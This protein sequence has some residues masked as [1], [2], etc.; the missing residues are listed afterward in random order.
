MSISWCSMKSKTVDYNRAFG[1]TGFF[2]S[3][4]GLLFHAFLNVVRMLLDCVKQV[5]LVLDELKVSNGICAIGVLQSSPKLRHLTS[6][7]R[8]S[9]SILRLSCSGRHRFRGRRR[10]CSC[11][12]CLTALAR[13]LSGRTQ[14]DSTMFCRGLCTSTTV[15]MT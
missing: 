7:S 8:G 14:Y 4:G 1:H 11:Y 2:V 9:S 10:S 6:I 13:W 5:S 3:V 12:R 15:F